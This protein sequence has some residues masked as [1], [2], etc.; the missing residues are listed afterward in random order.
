MNFT[1]GNKIECIFHKKNILKPIILSAFFSFLLF[2]RLDACIR[3]YDHISWAASRNDLDAVK[4]CLDKGIDV[5]SS[6]RNDTP[7]FSAANGGHLEM[8][9]FLEKRG[10]DVYKIDTNWRGFNPFH[11]AVSEGH[12]DV[13]EYFVNEREVDIEVKSNSG[14]TPLFIVLQSIRWS[15][16]GKRDSYLAIIKLL[17]EKG[18]DVNAKHKANSPFTPFLYTI[19]LGDLPLVRLFTNYGADVHKTTY[20][21]KFAVAPIYSASARG[22]YDIVEFLV[23]E[24]GVEVNIKTQVGRTDSSPWSGKS[25]FFTHGRATCR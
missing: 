17:L 4:A 3:P 10:A 16:S 20:S 5:N 21:Y 12:F 8:V 15:S 19:A 13:V 9:R 24:K 6:P 25:R 1:K 11:I 18:A 23:V 22:Y 14:E 2:Q 7:L